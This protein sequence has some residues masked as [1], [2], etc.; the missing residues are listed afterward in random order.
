[1]NRVRL[2]HYI[3]SSDAGGHS[4]RVWFDDMVVSTSRIGCN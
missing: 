2:Q 1:L 4:N 3:E